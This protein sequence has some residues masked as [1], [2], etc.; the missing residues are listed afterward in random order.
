MESN[1]SPCYSV[2]TKPTAITQS[3]RDK[4]CMSPL[5][6]GISSSTVHSNRV[7]NGGHPCLR[8]RGTGLSFNGCR[9]LYLQDEKVSKLFAQQ[10]ECWKPHWTMDLHLRWWISY[11]ALFSQLNRDNDNS[12]RGRGW[13]E[14]G[15]L[16]TLLVETW[17]DIATLGNRFQFCKNGMYTY[18][19]I[20]HVLLGIYLTEMRT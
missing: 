10:G 13:R 4:Y 6:W 19:T 18:H 5:T 16:H 20:H 17:R 3:Q 7:E 12:K 14:N 9:V 11:D 1:P 8:G 2:D 15:S